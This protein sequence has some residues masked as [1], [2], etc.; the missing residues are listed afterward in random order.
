MLKLTFGTK[1]EHNDFSGWGRRTQRTS[2]TDAH[3]AANILDGGHRA[4][5]EPLR[6]WSRTCRPRCRSRQALRFFVRQEGGRGFQPEKLT[7]YEWGYRVQPAEP[8]F[9]DI[10]T[11]YN[12]LR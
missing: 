5:Y 8:L 9:M 7:A 12:S 1:V 2:G 6:K 11:F 4:P 3:S 10:A